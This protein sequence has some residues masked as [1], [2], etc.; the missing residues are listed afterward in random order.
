MRVYR[1]EDYIE[2]GKSIHVFSSRLGRSEPPH[3]HDFIEIIYILSG[4]VIQIID[5]E[6]YRVRHGDC[7][8]I[9][10][11]STH[12]F[13]PDGEF[14]YFNI[15][16]SPETLGEAIVT[17]ENAFSLLS[18]TAFNEMRRDADGGK[19]SFFGGERKEIEDILSA[20][21]R[22]YRSKEKAFDRV[23]ESYLSIL[24]AKM[25][26]KTEAGVATEE[27]GDLWQE[28][29]EYIDEN[30]EAELTLS[31]LAGKCFYN[32]SYFS[33]VFKE[34][35]GM[36]LSAYVNR[37]RLERAIRLLCET[38][39]SVDEIS[40]RTGF[41]DRRNFYHAFAKYVGGTPS[42]YRRLHGAAQ[43]EKAKISKK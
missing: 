29:S 18:L 35:F 28:L 3:T 27:I 16:F 15:C 32:P 31:A 36:S 6:E 41:S 40:A 24:I 7:L 33:R 17:P 12:A 37:K 9:N 1:T 5:G 30:P 26:R 38:E 39:L 2:K 14:S 42:E 34:K 21:L 22:E 19:I 43:S 23:M 8:F 10:Y 4:Q 25:L 13:I 20:M 11:G